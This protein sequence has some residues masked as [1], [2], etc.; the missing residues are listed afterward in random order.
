MAVE[1]D[2]AAL[3]ADFPAAVALAEACPALVDAALA[4]DAA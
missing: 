3:S 2:D 1:A 4:D